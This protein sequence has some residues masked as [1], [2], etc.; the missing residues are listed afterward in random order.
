MYPLRGW[1]VVLGELLA[2]ATILTGVQ[3]C[4]LLLSV[5]MFSRFTAGGTIPL[6]TRLSIG[7]GVAIIAP[8]LDLISLVIP[9]ASVLLF[10][11][12]LQFGREPAGGS[13]VGGYRVRLR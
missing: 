3:W 13:A 12:W 7:G 2:P 8:M 6:A 9:S 4:L 1:Q 5:A 10:P 11:A